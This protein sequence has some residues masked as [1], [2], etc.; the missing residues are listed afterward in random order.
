MKWSN[1]PIT[2]VWRIILQHHERLNG[3][4]YPSGLKNDEILFEAKIIGV[5]DTYDAMT[6]D[7]LYRKGLSPE[8]SIAEIKELSG[9]LYEEV[10]VLALE[11]A[12]IESGVL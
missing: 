8:K 7:R 5:A 6:S 3:S 2:R 9:K 11:R 4:G 10:I 1:P 12:L